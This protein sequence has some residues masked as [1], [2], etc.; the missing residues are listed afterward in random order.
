MVYNLVT[1]VPSCVFS[2]LLLFLSFQDIDNPEKVIA[3]ALTFYALC[4]DD[5]DYMDDSDDLPEAVAIAAAVVR[6]H[7]AHIASQETATPQV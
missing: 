2:L 3:A 1:V 6:T 4:H 7:S 5:R